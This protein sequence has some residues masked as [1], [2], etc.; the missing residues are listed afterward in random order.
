MTVEAGYFLHA[1]LLL[2]HIIS[3]TSL[4]WL[5]I[6]LYRVHFPKV[7]VLWSMRAW[8]PCDS[9]SSSTPANLTPWPSLGSL[10]L[11][12]A[13]SSI[14]SYLLCGSWELGSSPA[15]APTQQYQHSRPPR[16]PPS[17]TPPVVESCRFSLPQRAATP[18]PV[19]VLSPAFLDQ[20]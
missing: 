2:S 3:C 7:I 8:S 19:C 10:E 13:P 18:S 11:H 9:C 4:S 14:F 12:P 20:S 6:I 5:H 16:R 1:V 15:A 17:R